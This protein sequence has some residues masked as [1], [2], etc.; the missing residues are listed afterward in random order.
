V[1]APPPYVSNLGSRLLPVARRQKDS[2]GLHNPKR[3]ALSARTE[4]QK[5][6]TT[7]TTQVLGRENSVISPQVHDFFDLPKKE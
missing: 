3:S 2:K 4:L 1:S 6:P 7:T 5:V